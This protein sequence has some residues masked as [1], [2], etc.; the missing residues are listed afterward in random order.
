MILGIR[1]LAPLA[2]G[3]VVLGCQSSTGDCAG[4]GAYAVRANI[5]DSA[6]GAPLAY[7]SSLI[8]RDGP[9]VDSVPYRHPAADS[10]TVG[11]IEA[12]L[13]RAGTYSVTVRREGSRV[14]TRDGVHAARPTGCG[15]R[16]AEVLVRLQPTG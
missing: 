5:R 6:S 9:Y 3:V 7:R 1:L 12:G 4:E 13:D 14:W 10:A 11:Y 2:A 16:Q 15:L 8:I